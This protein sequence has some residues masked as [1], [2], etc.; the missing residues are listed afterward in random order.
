MDREKL[1]DLLKR[2]LEPL[3]YELYH[4]ELTWQGRKRKLLVYIDRPGGVTLDD[5][6]RASRAIDALL[7]LEDPIPGPYLLEVSSPGVERGLWE[8]RH[9]ERVLG[10][11]IKVDL[12]RPVAGRKRLRAV[13][14]R[15]VDDEVELEVEGKLVSVPLGD[16]VRAHV[17]YTPE[18]T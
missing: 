4:W 16:I 14:R 8:K 6:V 15:V 3:G 13:L 12:A 1:D 17:V 10:K 5:C 7:D 18:G 11:T 9:Y 2:A